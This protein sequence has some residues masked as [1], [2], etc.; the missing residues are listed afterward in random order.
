MAAPEGEVTRGHVMD[1]PW[2]RIRDDNL[3]IVLDLRHPLPL[4]NFNNPP[5][6]VIKR[7]AYYTA[8]L[9]NFHH[10]SKL[11]ELITKINY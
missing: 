6:S 11:I 4:N 10:F 9:Q 8:P 2:T 5:A 1:D 3:I 7:S